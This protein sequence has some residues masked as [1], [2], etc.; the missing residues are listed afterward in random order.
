[1]LSG[2]PSL[3]PGAITIEAACEW[4][5]PTTTWKP[6]GYSTAVCFMTYLLL[7][8][9]SAVTDRFIALPVAPAL[10]SPRRSGA[11]ERFL[12]A[13]KPDPAL[14]LSPSRPLLAGEILPE[15]FMDDGILRSLCEWHDNERD[16]IAAR[17]GNAQ[18]L[19]GP[20][21]GSRLSPA[22]GSYS[23][24][25][26]SAARARVVVASERLLSRLVR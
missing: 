20:P 10:L 13:S 5:S 23:S 18:F 26:N 15:F 7:V 11:N 24:S 4:P 17:S 1:M 3:P 9:R 22:Y 14:F 25:G 6:E 8:S 12:G 19:A 21:I 2:P 16:V